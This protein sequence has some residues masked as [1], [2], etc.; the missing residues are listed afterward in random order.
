MM[1][2]NDKL[3]PRQRMFVTAYLSTRMNAVAAAIE[4]G[5]SAREDFS[6][7]HPYPRLSH[8]ERAFCKA[9]T[10]RGAVD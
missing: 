6:E 10:R 3:T 7:W 4:A 9:R 5:Y 1:P 2:F 8:I